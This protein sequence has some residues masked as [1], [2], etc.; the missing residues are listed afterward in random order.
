MSPFQKSVLTKHLAA[1]DQAAIDEAFVKFESYFLDS[2]RQKN[3]RAKK[4]EQFQEGFLRELFVKIFGYT[5]SPDPSFNL[6]TEL[7]NISDSKKADGA[8]L[9]DGQALG[10]IEL[11]CMKTKNLDK[12]EVQAFG[13]KNKQPGCVYVITSNFRFLRFYI[14]TAVDPIE[15]DLFTLNRE[16]FGVLYLI[17]EHQNL[18][19]GIPLELKRESLLKE[20]EIET[21]FY[22]D[23][24]N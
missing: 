2:K 20:K 22:S 12:V 3:I 14:E 10:V 13:Y 16:Q 15:F 24:S 8:I 19:S 6:E 5:I 18:L 17:L 11:K 23:Y 21:S 9:H 7:K 4:E 1:Q